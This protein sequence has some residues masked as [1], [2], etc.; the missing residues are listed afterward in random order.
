VKGAGVEFSDSN[1]D[2]ARRPEMEIERVQLLE[3][4]RQADASLYYLGVAETEC[5][6]LRCE[7]LFQS[8]S[9]NDE[10]AE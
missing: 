2:S 5:T 1:D 7:N 6:N 8:G 9:R 3:R 10:N 4:C